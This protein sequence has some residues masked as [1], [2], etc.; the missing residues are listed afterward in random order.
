MILWKRELKIITLF[1]IKLK[2]ESFKNVFNIKNN[3]DIKV[4]I[5][6]YESNKYTIFHVPLEY[7]EKILRFKRK[8]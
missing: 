3:K 7:P 6:L 8:N 4:Y 1:Y 5:E 2:D